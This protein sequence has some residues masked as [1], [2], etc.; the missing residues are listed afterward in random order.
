MY[1]Y[2]DLASILPEVAKQGATAI[3]VWPKVH[4]NQ[5]E[6]MTE[7][8]EEAFAALLKKH[9]VSLG[10]ITQ[11]K[12]GPFGLQEE[13]RLAKRFGCKTIVTGAVGPSCCSCP[14]TAFVTS[15]ATKGVAWWRL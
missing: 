3:D 5:R 1:G 6:H 14:V 10:C 15:L 13:M 12:L 11:Y 7:L 9:D 4:G 2:T 8:G